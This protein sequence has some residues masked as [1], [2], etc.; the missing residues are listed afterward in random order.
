MYIQNNTRENHCKVLNVLIPIDVDVYKMR[1][2]YLVNITN[3]ATRRFVQVCTSCA[4][5]A[6]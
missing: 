6:L 5:M 4:L 3:E 1:I 2:S